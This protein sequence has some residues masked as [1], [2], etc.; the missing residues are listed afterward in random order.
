MIRSHVKVI[1][2]LL[3]SAAELVP[4]SILTSAQK[5]RQNI[6]QR[7]FNE[8]FLL[9]LLVFIVL[10][11]RQIGNFSMICLIFFLQVYLF[12]VAI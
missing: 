2:T 3:M 9:F 6:P 10:L 5:K 7:S 11:L 12:Y 4:R 8:N 1:E